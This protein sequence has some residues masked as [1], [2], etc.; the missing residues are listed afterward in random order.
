MYEM[1]NVS[2]KDTDLP[3]D[4]WIDSEGKDR[5]A[6]SNSPII[7]VDVD[8]DMVPVSINEFPEILVNKTFRESGKV[9]RWIQ[10]YRG[11]LLSHWNKEITD[12][13]ALNELRN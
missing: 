5:N 13:E 7:Y 4:L 3:Y 12:R 10:R 11:V 2:R 1:A 8:G 6:D 9:L